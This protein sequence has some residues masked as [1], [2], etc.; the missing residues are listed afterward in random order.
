MLVGGSGKG[1]V[2][3]EGMAQVNIVGETVT[4]EAR[5]V[6]KS[7]HGWQYSQL[8]LDIPTLGKAG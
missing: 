2:G 1:G 6:G 8:I 4:R 3:G 5:M 7:S